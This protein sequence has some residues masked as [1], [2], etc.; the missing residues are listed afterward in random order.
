[1]Q[2]N[3]KY[4]ASSRNLAMIEWASRAPQTPIMPLSNQ[5]GK[6]AP[7]TT[8]DGAPPLH[9]PRKLAKVTQKINVPPRS[10]EDLWLGRDMSDIITL[11]RRT[12]LA[13]DEGGILNAFGPDKKGKFPLLS[14]FRRLTAAGGTPSEPWRRYIQTSRSALTY[15]RRDPYD[16][17]RG[18]LYASAAPGWRRLHSKASTFDSLRRKCYAQTKSCPW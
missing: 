15:W 14:C 2:T 13:R 12:G 11:Q 5:A 10:A 4:E 8:R 17:K 7:K 18:Y 16:Q 1:M 6:N 3:S 9:P